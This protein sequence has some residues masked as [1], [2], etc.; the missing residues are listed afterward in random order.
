MLPELEV[1]SQLDEEVLVGRVFAVHVL[2]NSYFNSGLLVEPSFVSNYFKRHV[3]T[4]LVVINFDNL[5]ETPFTQ[6][7]LQ[8][9]SVVHMVAFNQNIVSSLIVIPAIGSSELASIFQYLVSQVS[10]FIEL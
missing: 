7:F 4:L 1:L 9:V 2:Q 3:D 6:D 8:L 5:P 10:N